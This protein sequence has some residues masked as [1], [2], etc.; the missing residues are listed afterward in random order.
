MSLPSDA[1]GESSIPGGEAKIPYVLQQKKK[2]KKTSKNKTE[3]I[4]EQIQ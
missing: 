1:E 4:L 2:K 3:A